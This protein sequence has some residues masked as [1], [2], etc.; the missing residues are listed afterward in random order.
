MVPEV[1]LP[2]FVSVAVMVQLPAATPVMVAVAT[3]LAVVVAVAG[4]TVQMVGVVDANVTTSPA[5]GVAGALPLVT[6]AV[7][8]S[9]AV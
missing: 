8:G 7:T 9:V 2:P 6:V 3:P 1:P 4:A 5:T